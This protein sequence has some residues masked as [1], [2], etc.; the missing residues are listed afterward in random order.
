MFGPHLILE[1]Y[2]CPKETLA[3]M[4]ALSSILDAYPAQLDMTKIMP[5]YVFTYHGTVEDDWGVSGIVLIAESHISIHTF[6]EKGFVTLDIFSCRDF[7]VDAAVD[8]FCSVFK[9]ESFDKEILMRGREFPRS[10][11]KAQTIVASERRRL[12]AV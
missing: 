5:P 6:P 2:G 1:A 11:P 9:P 4:N 3:D 7:D 10:M 8:Y 12:T